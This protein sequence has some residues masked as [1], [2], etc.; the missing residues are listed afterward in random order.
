MNHFNRLF[1]LAL[2]LAASGG[3]RY[4]LQPDTEPAGM[5]IFAIAVLVLGEVF[6]RVDKHMASR[7]Q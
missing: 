4:K 6:Y 1:F 7:R 5:I 3:L 2:A